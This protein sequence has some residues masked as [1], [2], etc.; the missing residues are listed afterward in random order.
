MQA[1]IHIKSIII[2]HATSSASDSRDPSPANSIPESSFLQQIIPPEQ[3]SSIS[4]PVTI[5]ESTKNWRYIEDYMEQIGDDR[6]NWQ[7]YYRDGCCKG[8]FKIYSTHASLK[9]A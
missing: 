7:A 3:P 4:D 8:Y 2:T 1:P 9:N 6:M 5:D